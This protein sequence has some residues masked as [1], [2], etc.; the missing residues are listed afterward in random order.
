MYQSVEIN[1]VFIINKIYTA[2]KHKYDS[3]YYFGGE[4]HNFWEFVAVTEGE[5]GV[6]A[7]SEVMV[8][9]KGQAILHEPMEFHRLWSA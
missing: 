8:L 9:K 2:F 4:Y 6:T 1:N 5:I 7:G 3:N